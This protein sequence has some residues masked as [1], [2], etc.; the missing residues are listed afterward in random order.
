MTKSLF[1][2]SKKCLSRFMGL[3]VL[4]DK[5]V[6]KYYCCV[7]QKF[8]DEEAEKVIIQLHLDNGEDDRVR[9]ICGELYKKHKF[10]SLENIAIHNRII[11]NSGGYSYA[12][13]NSL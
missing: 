11:K 13:F 6:L 1:H 9:N 10:N 8:T 2:D 7:F 12:Y 4:G 3:V 5:L